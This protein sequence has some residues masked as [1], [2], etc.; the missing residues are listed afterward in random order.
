MSLEAGEDGTLGFVELLPDEGRHR[1]NQDVPRAEHAPRGHDGSLGFVGPQGETGLPSRDHPGEPCAVL[2]DRPH[3]RLFRLVSRTS[4]FSVAFFVSYLHVARADGADPML[5]L[6]A[7]QKRMPSRVNGWIVYRSP[8]RAHARVY[9]DPI[10]DR[11][12]FH[13]YP[14]A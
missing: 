11:D 7:G 10:F 9:P 6:N 14:R 2:L 12:V 3:D 8:H 5:P 1:A 4:L 13:A